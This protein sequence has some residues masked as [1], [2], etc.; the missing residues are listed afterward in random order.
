MRARRS[1]AGIA[2]V[3]A[4]RRR[5]DYETTDVDPRLL[6][7]LGA[8]LAVLL[9][10]APGVFLAAYPRARGDPPVRLPEPPPAPRLQ[11]DPRADLM[12]LRAAERDRLSTYGWV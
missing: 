5:P 1:D 11:L 7:A 6:G 2:M 3:E 10:A 12:P 4:S 8:G 9:I